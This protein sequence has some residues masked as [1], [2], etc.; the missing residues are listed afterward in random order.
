MALSVQ[1]KEKVSSEQTG[2][3]TD[4]GTW[5]MDQLK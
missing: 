5:G 3:G 2:Q 1:I 4:Y